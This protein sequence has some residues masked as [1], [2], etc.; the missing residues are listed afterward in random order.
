MADVQRCRKLSITGWDLSLCGEDETKAVEEILRSY[1]R[2][3][4]RDFRT[5]NRISSTFGIGAFRLGFPATNVIVLV[6]TAVGMGL[7]ATCQP[8]HGWSRYS[9]KRA[10]LCLVP[11]RVCLT[12]RTAAVFFS[13]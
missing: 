7:K 12:R 5:I 1:P 4:V 10:C 11:F 2:W 13:P 6:V 8:P 9:F 3:L